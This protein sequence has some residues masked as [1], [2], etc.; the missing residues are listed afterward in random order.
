VVGSNWKYLGTLKGDVLTSEHI[1]SL[2]F[3]SCVEPPVKLFKPDH[4][5]KSW[6][7]KGKRSAEETKVQNETNMT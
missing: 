2:V 1:A 4:Y 6:I 3:I 5:V 7:K